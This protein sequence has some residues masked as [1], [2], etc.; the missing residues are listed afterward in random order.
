MGAYK[1][2]VRFMKQ[3]LSEKVVQKIASFTKVSRTHQGIL[4]KNEGGLRWKMA[5]HP[6]FLTRAL[7]NSLRRFREPPPDGDSP[8]TSHVL[9]L[10]LTHRKD[11]QR[12]AHQI[13]DELLRQIIEDLRANIEEE[14]EAKSP[15]HPNASAVPRQL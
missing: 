2:M 11:R 14:L 1:A 8:S 12:R 4:C 9:C 5:P 3:P 6:T 13:G 15:P 10:L 7:A